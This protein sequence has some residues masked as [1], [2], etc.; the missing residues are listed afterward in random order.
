MPQSNQRGIETL[1]RGD[2]VTFAKPCLNR[3][4][5][6]LKRQMKSKAVRWA[7][8]PQSNQR[9]IETWATRPRGRPAPRLNRTSVG[10]KRPGRTWRPPAPSCLNRTSVGLKQEV[11]VPFVPHKDMPQSNQRGIETPL[12]GASRYR[13]IPGPQSNQRGIETTALR[14]G[15]PRQIE[16]GL[17]RTSVGLKQK[18][19]A[20]I[21]MMVS[22]ASIEPAWD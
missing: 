16:A 10:L 19:T 22:W 12:A 7:E 5:V 17:N 13:G 11:K 1:I 2:A 15:R 9:G 3:T 21:G 18:A 14:S 8:A 4:S 6:G 20:V